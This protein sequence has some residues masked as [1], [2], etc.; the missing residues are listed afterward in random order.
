VTEG[1]SRGR[2]KLGELI[3]AA[4]SP[5]E[6]PA[7]AGFVA[8]LAAVTRSADAVSAVADRFLAEGEA[9]RRI[10]LEW[11]ARLRVRMPG[12]LL[13]L[14]PTLLADP[15]LTR[16]L[17][18]RVAARAIRSSRNPKALLNRIVPLLTTG[19]SPLAAL[20]RLR[21]VQGRLSRSRALDR[22]IA[23]RE[24]RL[25]L[26]CPRCASRLRLPELARHL[27]EVHGLL[28]HNGRAR[29]PDRLLN[30][31]RR[32]YAAGRDTTILD[33]AAQIADPVALRAWA[34]RT[35]PTQSDIAA[36]AAVAADR[37]AGLCPHC[38]SE[39]PPSV[40][41]LPPPLV[42]SRGR[43][44]GEGYLVEVRGPDE[45]RTCTVTT[46]A[47][48]LR[49]GLDGR[50]AVGPR[51]AAALVAA[52]VVLAGIV[53]RVYTPAVLALALLAYAA[54]RLVRSPLPPAGDRAVDRAWTLLADRLADD[55]THDRFLTRLCRTSAGRGE[56]DA[57]V[58]A[59]HEV[60]VRSNDPAVRAAALFLQLDDTGRLGV[61]RVSGVAGLIASGLRGDEAVAFA[62]H[63][64][65]LFLARDPGPPPADRARL[66]VLVLDSAFAA[67]IT[68][69]GLAELWAGCPRLRTLT[70]VE[71]LSRLG[72]KY[73]V[74]MLRD[75]RPW[76]VS[77][78][79]GSVFDLARIAPTLGGRLLA[80]NPDLLLY[81]RPPAGVDEA[82]GWVLVCARGVIVGGEVV[83]DPDAEIRVEGGR[84][85][86][87]AT[88]VF[89]PHQFSLPRR[90]P[91]EFVTTLRRLLR[92]RTDV[93]LPRLDA[94]LATRPTPAMLIPLARRCR[95]GADVL[96][97]AGELGRAVRLNPA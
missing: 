77:A 29:N 10:L 83:A 39:L 90:P 97:A 34:A 23:R 45:L 88:L 11:L 67:G 1:G 48:V 16:D 75:G 50:R 65:E 22:L 17:Q 9:G 20:G 43:L 80:E 4:L 37:G 33:Q 18:V 19:L 30:D 36:A 59:V 28:L 72:L 60:T 24:R 53:A 2:I 74:W 52:A 15:V 58:E 44:S 85:I 42:L 7:H 92:L 40:E 3:D 68:P 93:L 27:Y 26:T 31:L 8:D 6:P 95:C 86:G 46:P 81:C 94:A 12:P 61:D 41:R 87:S 55:P 32:R 62:E 13:E 64:A 38:L 25:R 71:P 54:V 63:V 14:V 56:V 21:A 5:A 84:L 66:G 49:S 91:A 69:R 70:A 35:S 79:V 89:G 78:S 82:L 96:V 73:V 47:G 57:R 76:E 51:A